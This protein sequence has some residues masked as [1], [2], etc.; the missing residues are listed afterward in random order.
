MIAPEAEV[1]EEH[2]RRW[3][4][5]EAIKQPCL[6]LWKDISTYVV[7]RRSWWDWEGTKEGQRPATTTYDCTAPDALQTLVD[8]FQGNL[9]SEAFPWIR[10][11]TEDPELYRLPGVADYLELLTEIHLS[12]Y[13]RSSLYGAVGEFL[14]DY[15]GLGTGIMLV[16]D[17]VRKNRIQYS[18]R[19]LKECA[20]GE[21]IEGSVDT[22]YRR[23]RLT[24]RQVVTAWPDKASK[25]RQEQAKNNPFGPAW[26]VHGAYP[27]D[28][29]NVKTMENPRHPFGS[30]YID[31]ADNTVLEEGGYDSFPYLVARWRKNSDEVYGR[32]PAGDAIAAIL[33]VNAM[34]SELLESAQKANNPAV[35]APSTMKG[36]L[37]LDAGGENYFTRPGEEIQVVEQ[38]RGYPITRDQEEDVREQIRS[39][40]RSRV[41]MI[42]QALQGQAAQTATWV[43]RVVGEQAIMLSPLV[44]RYTGEFAIPLVRRS[45][46]IFMRMGI[47][48]PPPEALMGALLK[49]ELLGPLA[50]TQ[51]KYHQTQGVQA[52][53]EFLAGTAQLFPESLDNA[54]PDELARIGMDAMGVPQRIIREE[55]AVELL[56]LNRSRVTQRDQAAQ[57]GIAQDQSVLDKADRLN[58][59]VVPGSLLEQLIRRRQQQNV[60]GAA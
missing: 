37:D 9:I 58:K 14:T 21:D 12:Y 52:G 26:I 36:K 31:Q 34:A 42:L 60:R 13:T 38:H 18:T 56:R 5:L 41:F 23:F 45:Q 53:L 27:T 43:N 57:A 46:Q 10:M 51:R 30:C 39:M 28:E 8:G 44:G 32:G 4:T 19:H 49:L 50:Q 3:R 24:N 59:P 2:L 54:D 1:V 11:T 47:V 17:N 29:V 25:S 20:I 22:L 35:F 40:F 48:P 15:A 55:P 6:P 33:R 16:Q 7:P